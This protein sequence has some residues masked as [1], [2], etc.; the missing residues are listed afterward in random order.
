MKIDRNLP[1]N[2]SKPQQNEKT[3]QS[4]DP[5]ELDLAVKI[6]NSM[7]ENEKTPFFTAWKSVC[8]GH[9]CNK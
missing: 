8:Q 3:K 1:K 4:E 2:L 9:E 7:Q 6:T 5:Y